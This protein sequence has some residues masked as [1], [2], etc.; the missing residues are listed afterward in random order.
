MDHLVGDARVS[1]LEPRG[2]LGS[3]HAVHE[4]LARRRELHAQ[5]LGELEHL[6]EQPRLQLVVEE[7][8]V[9]DQA[10]LRAEEGHEPREIRHPRVGARASS[11]TA[12]ASRARGG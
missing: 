2:G 5:E 7:P 4:S 10:S 8:R 3:V 12:P 1:V 11:P 6:D 9:E